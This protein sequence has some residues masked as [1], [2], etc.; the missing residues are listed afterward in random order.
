MLFYLEPFSPKEECRFDFAGVGVNEV[1][2][3]KTINRPNGTWDWLLMYFYDPVTV[4]DKNGLQRIDGGYFIIWRPEDGH[5]YGNESILWNHTWCHFY[6]LQVAD[7]IKATGLPTNKLIKLDNPEVLEHFLTDVYEE[8]TRDDCPDQVILENLFTI[9]V[10]K[11]ARL[12]V[13]EFQVVQLPEKVK[14]TKDFIDS[15]YMNKMTLA[16]LATLNHCS[17]QY[18]SRQFRRYT[19][20]SPG[21]YIIKTRINQAKY[22]LH[23]LSLNVTEVARLVSYES[24]Y[25]FSNLFKK[26]TGMSPTEYRE[27][28][29]SGVLKSTARL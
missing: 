27:A 17:I 2:D 22:H 8:K 3:P 23:N 18:L 14:R 29:K 15:H 11:L 19:G 28:M 6:G 9:L 10:R 13:P 16:E 1:M 25:Q 5:Y 4:K 21:D 7:I 12:V 24:I 20:M 26:H